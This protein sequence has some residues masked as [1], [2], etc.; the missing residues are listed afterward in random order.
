[1]QD[2]ILAAVGDQALAAK[3]AALE[4]H[5]RNTA[6]RLPVIEQVVD[7]PSSKGSGEGDLEREAHKTAMYLYVNAKMD[8]T[9][10]CC[11]TD[12][13]CGLLPWRK[14]PRAPPFLSKTQTSVV[15]AIVGLETSRIADWVSTVHA[16]KKPVCD[17]LILID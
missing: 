9:R 3:L 8:D 14:V 6:L 5:I 13:S 2:E 15:L 12:I 17:W 10:Y 11:R 4:E 16:Y 7:Q 1:L